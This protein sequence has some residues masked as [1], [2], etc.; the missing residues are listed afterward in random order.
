[1]S[2]VRTILVSLL[3]ATSMSAQNASVEQ[4]FAT[5]PEA[6]Q[7]IV[8]S[9]GKD[10]EL[11]AVEFERKGSTTVYEVEFYAD[12]VMTELEMLPNGEVVEIEQKVP[13]DD[14][15]ET[16]K[17]SIDWQPGSKRRIKITR[18]VRTVYEVEIEG[19][20][21][22]MRYDVFGE[23]LGAESGKGKEEDDD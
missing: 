23:N 1:M 21:G 20:R 5:M 16:L 6:C 2:I 3:L 10:I 11:E 7:K 15:S 13:Y 9:Y 12:G 14:L 17:K 8:M 19:V 18:V 22:T 4:D